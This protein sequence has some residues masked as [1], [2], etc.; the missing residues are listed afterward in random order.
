M[1]NGLIREQKAPALF[2]DCNSF[3]EK[4]FSERI[5]TNM[6]V[7]G[8]EVW[9]MTYIETVDDLFDSFNRDAEQVFAPYHAILNESELRDIC[10][11]SD[12]FLP[13]VFVNNGKAMLPGRRTGDVLSVLEKLVSLGFYKNCVLDTDEG[14][15][16]Y[17][18]SVI[19]E[20]Y[21]ST[22]PFIDNPSR[23]TGFQNVITPYLI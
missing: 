17:T 7:K 6:K 1:K 2:V 11:V 12:S 9:F 8:A 15:D 20:D 14:L 5:M 18:W 16:G 23:L 10:S 21:P 3:R 22:L 19:A 4:G 13:V